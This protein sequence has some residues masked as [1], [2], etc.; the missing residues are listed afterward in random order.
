[1]AMDRDV[2]GI[3]DKRFVCNMVCNYSWTSSI[4]VGRTSEIWVPMAQPGITGLQ[5]GTMG[6]A[7]WQGT[8]LGQC[9]LRLSVNTGN[10]CH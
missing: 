9:W 4:S 3:L 7:K 10:H 1:M 8:W 5:M 6:A 2:N